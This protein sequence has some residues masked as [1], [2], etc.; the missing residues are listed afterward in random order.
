MCVCIAA[1][2]VWVG[3]LT[4]FPYMEIAAPVGALLILLMGIN[5][6]DGISFVIARGFSRQRQSPVARH[7]DTVP[8]A[9]QQ[10]AA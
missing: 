10:P 6:V 5:V 7:A 1:F 2:A 9:R 8:P 3:S 4:L